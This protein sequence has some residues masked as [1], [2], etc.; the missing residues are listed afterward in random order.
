MKLRCDDNWEYGSG[1]P[2]GK[3][4]ARNGASSFM[5][6]EGAEVIGVVSLERLKS[7]LQIIF[8]F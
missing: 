6:T 7:V 3:E 1:L 2:K 4:D 5:L 8:C